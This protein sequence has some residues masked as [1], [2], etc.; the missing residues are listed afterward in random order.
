VPIFEPSAYDR[1]LAAAVDALPAWVHDALG[2]SVIRVEHAL[3]ADGLMPVRGLRVIVYREPSIS[4]ARDDDELARFARA[5]LVR[6]IT[7]QLDLP[8]EDA[9]AQELADLALAQ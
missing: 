8:L 2:E 5:D 7:W 4:R 9:A 1:A 3:R 6:A